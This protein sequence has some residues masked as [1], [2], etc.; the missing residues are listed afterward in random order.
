MKVLQIN[1]FSNGSTGKIMCDIN[2][3]LCSN[4]VE[5]YMVWARGRN[6]ENDHQFS[7]R[8]DLGIKFHGVYTRL[9]D[10]HGFASWNATRRLIHFIKDSKPNI[11]HIHN[12]HGYY[13]N[14][15]ILFDFFRQYNKP[16]VWT[17]HDCWSF[18]GHCAHFELKKC[19]KW[20]TG[21][22]ECPQ[23]DTY[24][25]SVLFDGSKKN[26][27]D[28]KRIFEYKK[29][30]IVCPSEWLY[31]YCVQSFMGRNPISVIH[32][33]IDCGVFRHYENVGYIKQKYGLSGKPIILGVAS[34]WTERKGLF[35]LYQIKELG[36]NYEVV[37][38]GLNEEQHKAMPKSIIGIRRTDNQQ[39]LAMLYSASEVLFNPTYEDNYPTVNLE[40][41]ACGTPVITY[42]T[43]GSV[44]SVPEDNIIMQ[45]DVEGAFVKIT[46][47]NLKLANIEF[48]KD[49]MSF[50]YYS[51]Y[52]DIYGE[53]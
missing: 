25:K 4:G 17:L 48:S 49:N 45:G 21:C 35:D 41:Q 34:E 47:G 5:S 43:G 15:E 50:K 22:Y 1:S 26:W 18:T 30:H 33:G 7:V 37:V 52:K 46:G 10:R 29:L 8:D 20:K 3:Y 2:D 40:A 36:E 14:I 9:F 31:K 24:P 13:I 32:N 53:N 28:K 16:V 39:E 27:R 44:E 51:L 6:A 12:L 23:K 38:V 19:C 11:I 42:K